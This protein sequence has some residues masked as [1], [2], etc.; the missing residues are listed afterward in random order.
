MCT[1]VVAVA[2]VVV[3][4]VMVVAVVVVVR[5]WSACIVWKMSSA[6]TS[7]TS[8]LSLFRRVKLRKGTVP[9]TKH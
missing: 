5:T 8:W 6:G 2:V 9:E 4:V 7:S 1:N 3:V